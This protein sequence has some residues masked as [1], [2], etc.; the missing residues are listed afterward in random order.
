MI[1]LVLY[2][3]YSRKEVHSIFSQDTPFIPR[4]GS[5]GLHTII[6]LRDR[7]G[8]YIFFTTQTDN[9]KDSEI[10]ITKQGVFSWK[11]KST[12]RLNDPQIQRFVG[13]DDL[14]NSIYLFYR[15]KMLGRYTYMG[16]LK[17]LRHDRSRECPV[18]IQWQI[19]EWNIS[20]KEVNRLGLELQD[21]PRESNNNEHHPVRSMLEE[22]MPP[23]ICLRDGVSTESFLNNKTPDYSYEETLDL[24]LNIAGEKIVIAYEKRSLIESGRADLAHMV[25][26]VAAIEGEYAAYDVES[27]TPQGEVKYI[28]VKTTRGSADTPFYL[29]NHELEFARRHPDN[30]YLYRVYE[31]DEA[32]NAGKLYLSRGNIQERFQMTPTGY[33]VVLIRPF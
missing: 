2:Q 31:Y 32:L 26:H 30:Y 20:Q 11:S 19:L 13:H 3:K 15:Q 17:Y 23:Q 18:Y 27:Y 21:I 8:D 22:T 25:R 28:E 1:Q 33:R 9:D 5:W 24:D 4:Q 10:G 14:V 7:L 12:Q 16:R 29:R 6:S